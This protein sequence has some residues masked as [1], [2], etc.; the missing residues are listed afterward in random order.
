MDH[1]I[2]SGKVGLLYLPWD[3][4]YVLYS[5]LNK[6]QISGVGVFPSCDIQ[7]SK[8]HVMYS[9]SQIMNKKRLYYYSSMLASLFLLTW[10]FTYG[11][12]NQHLVVKTMRFFQTFHIDFI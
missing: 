3:I 7:F 12:Y 9:M 4:Q 2:Q 8:L 5:L 6:Q 11:T 1:H 10:Y